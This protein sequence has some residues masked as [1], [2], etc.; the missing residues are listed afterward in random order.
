MGVDFGSETLLSLSQAAKSLPGRPHLSTI[1]RWHLR[2]VKGI[3]LET[4]CIGGKRFTSVEALKRFSD[5]TTAAADGKPP[6]RRTN[7]QRQ[8]D[9][10]AAEQELSDA[11]I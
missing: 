10:A 2:G 1:F 6:S 7:R 5:E 9:L 3:R 4:C 8:R 11:G